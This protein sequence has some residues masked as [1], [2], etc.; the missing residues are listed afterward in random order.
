MCVP[1]FLERV[2]PTRM[3]HALWLYGYVEFSACMSTLPA[4]LV[5]CAAPFNVHNKQSSNDLQYFMQAIR[6]T[7]SGQH[8]D[9]TQ[10]ALV[11]NHMYNNAHNSKNQWKRKANQA[12]GLRN[13]SFLHPRA[14]KARAKK[15]LTIFAENWPKNSQ[16]LVISLSFFQFDAVKGHSLLSHTSKHV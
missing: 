9:V 12:H 2:T 14:P 13:D 6:T 16:K 4:T 1:L 11:W 8:R 15:I 5:V 7:C 3:P 10:S